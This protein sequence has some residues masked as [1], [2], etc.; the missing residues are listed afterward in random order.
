MLQ[1]VGQV[2]NFSQ[3]FSP[4]SAGHY[5]LRSSFNNS[6]DIN[7][8]ND[9]A[10]AELVVVDTNGTAIDL[11][12]YNGS[13]PSNLNV[14]NWSG[15]DS[16]DGAGVYYEPPYYPAT[17]S[18]VSAFVYSTA[19]LTT[20]DAF[21]I[22]VYDDD[23]P[24]G[25]G[26]LLATAA[27]PTAQFVPGSWNEVVFNTPI[28]I[29]SGGFYVGWY[30]V[31]GD[32]QLAQETSAPL[33]LRSFEI[34]N[35]TWSTFRFNETQE[36][37]L[38]VELSKSC[39]IPGGI[40]LGADTAI[41]TGN[42]LTLSPGV[43][44]SSYSWTNGASSASISISSAGTYGVL[45]EDANGC[46]AEDSISVSLFA[47]PSVSLGNDLVGCDGDTFVI[48]ADM[49]FSSYQWST[50]QTDSSII[51]TLSNVYTLTVTDT[52]GCTAV[53]DVSVLLNPAPLVDLGQDQLVCFGNGQVATAIS[54]L[55]GS[56]LWSTG[57]TTPSIT[58]GQ[59][60][61][62]WLQYTDMNGCVGSDTFNVSDDTP[63]INLGP[64]T[65]GC[66]GTPLVLD[67]GGGFVLYA[68][69]DG[70]NTQTNAVSMAG[71]YSVQ[72]TN[73]TGCTASDTITVALDPLPTPDFSAMGGQ[74]ANWFNWSFTNLS[75]DANSYLWDFG[76][77]GSTSTDPSPTH[78]Y[79][80]PGDYE[81]SLIA[82][83]DCGS[84]TFTLTIT[85]TNTD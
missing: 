33:S 16:D 62:Y 56:Y 34:L 4:P 28:D 59:P 53:D 76:D 61:T 64:D 10:R 54:N 25:L 15:G 45:V 60:G 46:T 21:E 30:Q 67:A 69:S 2:I 6:L 3:S 7:P 8:S 77:G 42:S 55:P 68:W 35:N 51:V 11:T 84:D 18:S 48:A 13:T 47:T 73:A 22:R 1:G 41:C 63:S 17:I 12:Y 37:L 39:D 26:T 32:V 14:L 74:G 19:P 70:T 57:E 75:V 85:L 49:G 5:S 66:E 58:I 27:M 72:I 23:A 44:A 82:T 83:N 38:I 50:G 52:N 29:Q 71:D 9:S 78:L 79:A 43:M 24:A 81:V 80:F 40:S 36:C 20:N 31:G 65:I